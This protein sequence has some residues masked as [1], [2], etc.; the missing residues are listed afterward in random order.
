[1]AGQQARMVITDPPYNVPIQG[2][3]CGKG[4]HQHPEFAV[5]CGELSS[6]AFISFL[7]ESLMRLAAVSVDGAVH[8]L[9]MDWRH[10]RELLTAAAMVYLGLLFVHVMLL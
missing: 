10:A 3:V 7:R 8:Y 1:M 5:A 2:H 4:R 9:F 6:D